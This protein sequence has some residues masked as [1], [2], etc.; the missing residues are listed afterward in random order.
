MKQNVEFSFSKPQR[1]EELNRVWKWYEWK[2][3]FIKFL[4]ARLR[5]ENSEEECKCDAYIGIV[6]I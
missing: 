6:N 5:E 4:W 2:S 1:G 3:H